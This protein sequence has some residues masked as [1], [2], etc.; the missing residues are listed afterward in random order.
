[1]GKGWKRKRER[2]RLKE[3]RHQNIGTCLLQ[4]GRMGLHCRKKNPVAM[5]ALF[6]LHEYSW[7]EVREWDSQ[8][9]CLLI[10]VCQSLTMIHMENPAYS[11]LILSHILALQVPNMQALFPPHDLCS[12]LPRMVSSRYLHDSFFTSFGSL[13]KSHSLEMFSP[14]ASFLLCCSQQHKPL[15][16]TLVIYSFWSQHSIWWPRWKPEHEGYSKANEES[17]FSEALCRGWG[18]LGEESHL[19]MAGSGW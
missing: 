16:G 15:S 8:I 13:F 7:V 3:S 2:L 19:G 18:L 1:M 17:T 4:R 5:I 10:S 12:P 14:P 11:Q 6:F 9:L